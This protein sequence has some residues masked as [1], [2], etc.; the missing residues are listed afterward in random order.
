MPGGV[1]G[2]TPPDAGRGPTDRRKRGTAAVPLQSTRGRVRRPAAATSEGYDAGVSA[3]YVASYRVTNPDGFRQYPSAVAP[4]I[5]GHGGEILVADLES[6]AV[7]GN[8]PH[9]TIV[10]RFPSKEAVRTWYESA[11]YRA[12]KHHRLD[13]TADGSVVFANEFVLPA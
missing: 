4:T 12:I 5:L 13:H 7:E 1:K 8:P 2:A 6:E 9:V 10:L 11:E 3:D